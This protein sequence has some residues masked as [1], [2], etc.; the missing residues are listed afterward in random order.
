MKNLQVIC[1]LLFFR[2]VVNG[3][4][5][6]QLASHI[7]WEIYRPSV[8]VYL[9]MNII[10]VFLFPLPMCG[11]CCCCLLPLS[12]I[13]LPSFMAIRIH[14]PD[15]YVYPLSAHAS[16]GEGIFLSK[17]RKRNE[18]FLSSLIISLKSFLRGSLKSLPY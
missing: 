13:W 17:G 11:C 10:H 12:C 1:L 2:V 15:V 5:V 7:G 14:T 9:P 16:Y 3:Q 18:K 4:G 8:C 6:F